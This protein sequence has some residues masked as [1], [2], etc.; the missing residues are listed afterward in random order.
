[1]SVAPSPNPI[2]NASGSGGPTSKSK[3]SKG[4]GNDLNASVE[5]WRLSIMGYWV[6]VMVGNERCRKLKE[7]LE[8]KEWKCKT[9]AEKKKKKKSTED[10]M[11]VGY[12]P[13]EDPCNQ[14]MDTR[15]ECIV[16]DGQKASKPCQDSRQQCSFV[17]CRGVVSGSELW[18]MRLEELLVENQEVVL[19]AGFWNTQAA[20]QES[21]VMALHLHLEVM[22]AEH[23][24]VLLPEGFQEE[25]DYRALKT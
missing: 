14:C 6:H 25:V 1:M 3:K 2:N 23:R 20:L 13:T 5:I 17:N 15:A 16:T 18:L 21:A 8:E 7:E 11:P 24:G 9:A 12:F 10:E 19:Q 4:K 22:E